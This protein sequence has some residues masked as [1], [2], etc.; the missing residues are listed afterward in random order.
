MRW[1]GACSPRVSKAWRVFSMGDRT[2]AIFCRSVMAIGAIWAA[3]RLVE[4]GGRR[5]RFAQHRRR[6]RALGATFISI[7][8]AHAL[9]QLA[10]GGGRPARTAQADAGRPPERWAG[11]RRSSIFAAALTGYIAF[12]TF[13]VNQ[14]IYLT[15]LGSAL[16]LANLI[17]QDGTEALLRPDCA[18]WRTAPH[19]AR[20]TPQHAR[21]DRGHRSG[22]G[23]GC[24]ADHRDRRGARTVGRAVAGHV[25]RPC[26]QPISASGSAASLCPCR[27]SLRRRSCSRWWSPPL[28]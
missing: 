12:A 15:V 22:P 8:I 2:A 24:G 17:V 27:R 5:G 21:P 20:A 13:L 19:H 23:P 7:V 18:G 14:G 1:R 16:Y 10:R 25:R 4:A 11:P 26:A 6:R 3:E 9:R 28:G